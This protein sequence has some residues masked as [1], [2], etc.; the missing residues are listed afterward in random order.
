VL[1]ATD[2]IGLG[3]DGRLHPYLSAAG[4]GHAV[5]D[6]VAAA[7]SLAAAHAGRDWVVV[8]VSQGGHAALVTNEQAAKRLPSAHLLGAVAVAPGSQLGHTYGDALQSRIII[9]MVL[10]GVEAQDPS[11]DL[12]DYLS[13]KSRPAVTAIETGCMKDIIANAGVASTPD[14]FIVDPRSTPLGKA[15]VKENDPGQVRSATPL[16]LVQ[17]G[18][19]PLVLP[20]RTAALFT[21]L[22]GLGQ[23]VDKVDIPAGTHDTVTDLAKDQIARWVAA[24]FDGKPAADAC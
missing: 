20:A 2:Y 8:G 4:E 11:V 5:I 24:R 23:V 6:G 7:R 12:D 16:L 17:G 14:Y 21:R 18:Q 15:W 9:T 1:V 3:P 22:C 13:P 19:D 10:V